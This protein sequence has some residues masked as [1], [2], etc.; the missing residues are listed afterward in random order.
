IWHDDTSIAFT[1]SEYG[2]CEYL[3]LNHGQVFSREKIYENVFGYEGESDNRVIVEHIKNIRQ[4]LGKHD[5]N[6]IETVWGIGYK[7]RK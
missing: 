7:W 5:M 4:K 3:A 2:I 1:K 6:P